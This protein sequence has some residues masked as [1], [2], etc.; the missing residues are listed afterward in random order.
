M[1]EAIEAFVVFWLPLQPR[2]KWGIIEEAGIAR[3]QYRPGRHISVPLQPFRHGIMILLGSIFRSFRATL[4][5]L[6]LLRSELNFQEMLG[7]KRL[8][9]G[10]TLGD[11]LRPFSQAGFE[12]LTESGLRILNRPALQVRLRVQR[13]S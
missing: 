12:H 6:S 8:G 13:R 7:V 11:D 1:V 10:A 9:I 4:C 3:F 5:N 2:E